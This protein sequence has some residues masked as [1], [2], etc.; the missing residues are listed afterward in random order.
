MQLYFKPQGDLFSLIMFDQRIYEHPVHAFFEGCPPSLAYIRSRAESTFKSRNSRKIFQPPTWTAPP[1]Y[2]SAASA[3]YIVIQRIF[4]AY[5][6][7]EKYASRLGN[8]AR[9]TR[10]SL[11]YIHRE[12]KCSLRER[13]RSV[14]NS[15]CL[16]TEK[17]NLQKLKRVSFYGSRSASPIRSLDPIALH[18]EAA[19]R[20]LEIVRFSQPM[21][22]LA[23]A[24]F[25]PFFCHELALQKRLE[26][27][28][29]QNKTRS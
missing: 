29:D 23:G 11:R 19:S 24:I 16:R 2:R 21:H 1:A 6:D 28:L 9:V 13:D 25:S 4:E 15:Y 27:S 18:L 5:Q 20:N 26:Y 22:H 17:F 8:I 7:I 3:L 12:Y 10:A 14:A